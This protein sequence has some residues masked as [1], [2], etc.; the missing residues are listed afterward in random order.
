MTLVTRANVYHESLS[1]LY[2]SFIESYKEPKIIDVHP[3]FS[4][5]PGEKGVVIVREGHGAVGIHSAW[6]AEEIARGRIHWRMGRF[7][8]EE[9]QL[10]KLDQT[11]SL[12]PRRDEA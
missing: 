10:L 4:R 8:M 9:L 3:E 6:T 5:S 1:C 11:R 12:L 2:R 7:S